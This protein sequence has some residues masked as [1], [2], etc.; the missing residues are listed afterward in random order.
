MAAEKQSKYYTTGVGVLIDENVTTFSRNNGC[1]A[2]TMEI[3]Q[4]IV[5]SK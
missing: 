5:Y 2:I 3:L 4:Q 1:I